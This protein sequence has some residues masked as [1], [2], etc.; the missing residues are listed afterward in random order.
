MIPRV[1][2]ALL[3]VAALLLVP[4]S[5]AEAHNIPSDVTVEAFV[6]PQGHT[7]RVVIR[8]PMAAMRD[9]EWPLR[10]G[11]EYID[12]AASKKKLADAAQIWL[13]QFIHLFEDGRELKDWTIT[14]TRLSKP[15]DRSFQSYDRALAHLDDPPLPEDVQ[16]PWN[17]GMLDAMIEYPIQ[18]D[19]ARFALSST[20]NRLGIR[21]TTVIRFLT[22]EGQVRAYEFHDNPGL[23]HLDPSILQA[24][25]R[26]VQQGIKHILSGIDHVLFLL[27][28]VI[29][30][31]KLRGLVPVVTSFTVAHSITLIASASGLAPQALWF[32]PLI[33]TLIALSIVYM[34][35]ENIVGAKLERRWFITFGFG[36]VHGFGFSFALSQEFQFAGAHLLSS[37]LSFN[38]GVEIGQLLVL[39]AVIPALHLL[40]KYGVQE[41][42]GIIIL[43]ALVAHTAWHWFL[44]RGSQLLQYDF[45]FPTLDVAFFAALMRW[46]MMAL[47]AVGI[48][49]A[50]YELFKRF[51]RP[52]VEEQLP[53]GAGAEEAA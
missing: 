42:M 9:I 46:M 16:L 23:V 14:D 49:W 36:L 7:L 45:T 22:P 52:G 53:A 25:W 33:E 39:C 27:C 12:V 24:S 51:E 48:V 8:A 21:T 35:L 28:L 5:A 11:G 43:S 3:A 38:L 2:A 37:L 18:S 44:D 41:R 40:F 17:Q 15:S 50:M 6:K 20:L 26:F 32:P 31:R 34:A 29:P 47:I 4:R 13:A 19:S 30:F 1:A 10:P